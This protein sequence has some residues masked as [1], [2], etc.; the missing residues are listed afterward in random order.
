MSGHDKAQSET[1]E[2]IDSILERLVSSVVGLKLANAED[3][4]E[5]VPIAKAKLEAHQ[6]RM[7]LEAEERGFKEGYITA[8][9][10]HAKITAKMV[11]EEL[12]Q[13]YEYRD[14][15]MLSTVENRIAELKGKQDG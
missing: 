2:D 10:D 11:L 5:F 3:Y 6:K 14:T 8:E 9:N 13:L 7:V 4:R 12:Q 1:T 15:D